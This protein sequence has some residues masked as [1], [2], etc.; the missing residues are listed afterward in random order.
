M[1]NNHFAAG[2]GRRSYRLLTVLLGI[3]FTLSFTVC[4][5]LGREAALGCLVWATAAV[6]PISLLATA[7]GSIREEFRHVGASNVGD[8]SAMGGENEKKRRGT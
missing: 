1:K 3:V 6:L 5:Y 2:I 4:I 8:G 7:L